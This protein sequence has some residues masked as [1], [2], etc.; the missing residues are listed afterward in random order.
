MRSLWT[1]PRIWPTSWWIILEALLKESENGC[2]YVFADNNQNFYQKKSHLDGLFDEAPFDLTLNCR[3]TRSIH[4]YVAHYYTGNSEIECTGPEGRPV[5]VVE[6]TDDHDLMKKVRQHLHTLIVEGQVSNK[7]VVV[8]TLRR[9]KRTGFTPGTKL[10]NYT[11]VDS[12]PASSTEVHVSSVHRFKG[13]ESKVVLL[14][15]KTG[16][17]VPNLPNLLTSRAREQ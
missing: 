14:V 17:F 13:L 2:L 15:E 12:A 9:S 3:N 1:R 8:L 4:E 7:D 10:G 16:V 5:E 11:L 6:Y